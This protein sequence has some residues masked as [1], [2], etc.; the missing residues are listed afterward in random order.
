[1][2]SRRPGSDDLV[3][4]GPGIPDLVGHDLPIRITIMGCTLALEITDLSADLQRCY[5]QSGRLTPTN[6][7]KQPL[8]TIALREMGGACVPL[9]DGVIS[10]AM[11]A[12]N[13]NGGGLQ[14]MDPHVEAPIRRKGWK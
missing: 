9:A 3:V 11:L 7:T 2:R 1:M 13:S 12:F 14:G 6:E 4:A 10:I 8:V 5:V